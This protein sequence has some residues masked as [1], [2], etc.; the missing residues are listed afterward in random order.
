MHYQSMIDSPSIIFLLYDMS[1]KE[2]FEK[3]K[4]LYNDTRIRCNSNP[5]ILVGNKRDRK[6]GF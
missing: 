6:K 2:S 1:D 5:I 4:T 3:I